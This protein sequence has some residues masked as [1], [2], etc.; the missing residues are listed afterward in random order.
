MRGRSEG[1]GGLGQGFVA[2]GWYCDELIQ[3]FRGG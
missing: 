1:E 2:G 3:L